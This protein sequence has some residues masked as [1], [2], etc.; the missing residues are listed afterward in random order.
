VLLWQAVAI[1]AWTTLT[2][3]SSTLAL[4]LVGGIG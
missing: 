2:A 4:H 1:V 3:V